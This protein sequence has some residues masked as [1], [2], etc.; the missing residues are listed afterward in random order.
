METK[1]PVSQQ[2]DEI[3]KRIEPTDSET[4]ETLDED[5]KIET[6][7][8]DNANLIREIYRNKPF[9]KKE[10]EMLTILCEIGESYGLEIIKAS[11][12]KF[13]RGTV[14]VYLTSMVERGLVTGEYEENH[15]SAGPRRRK[16]KVTEET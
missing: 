3:L 16:F 4:A 8:E 6:I 7:L 2:L 1:T 12:G 14:Y 11:G 15:P 13:K 10:V 5:K 9:T